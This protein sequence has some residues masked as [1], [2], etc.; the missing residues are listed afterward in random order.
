MLRDS[1]PGFSLSISVLVS[2]I[3][4][5]FVVRL[6]FSLLAVD[7]DRSFGPWSSSPVVSPVG[8]RATSVIERRGDADNFPFS[9]VIGFFADGFNSTRDPSFDS[10]SS[11][12]EVAFR[13]A[14][15]FV[16]DRSFVS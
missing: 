16:E 2:S 8:V 4:G 7:P 15:L 9:S 14:D 12:T 1:F 11:V 3:A 13:L 10:N 5:S 6:C